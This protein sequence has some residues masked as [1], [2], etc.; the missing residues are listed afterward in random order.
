MTRPRL[1]AG[2]AAPRLLDA[3]R[4]ASKARDLRRQ[5]RDA[6]LNRAA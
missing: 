1:L 6:L 5:R 3:V 2:A 4:Q